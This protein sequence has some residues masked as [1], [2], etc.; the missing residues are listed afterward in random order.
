MD[1]HTDNMVK[2][3]FKCMAGLGYMQEQQSLSERT[4]TLSAHRFITD[5]HYT[6]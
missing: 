6:V 4:P 5:P 3:S 1:L 2:F